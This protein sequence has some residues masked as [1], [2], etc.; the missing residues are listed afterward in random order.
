VLLRTN[1]AV[2]IGVL[3][4]ALASQAAWGE[5]L[6]PRSHHAWGRFPVGSWKQ[7]RVQ[8][9]TLDAKGNVI[10]ASTT[11]TV[12]V[13]T[14][15]DET[16]Y[17]LEVDVTL[18][19]AGKRFILQP[20]IMH[21]GFSG[22]TNGQRAELRP[23][24]MATV[25]I[26]GREIPTEVRES[27]VDDDECQ[28]VN[29]VYYSASVEP[30]VLKRETTCTGANGEK[31]TSQ[32]QVDVLALDM[33]VRLLNETMTSSHVKT[34]QKSAKGTA[35]TLE[36]C[37]MEVPGGVVYHTAKELDS[38]GRVVR[39]GT[40]EIVDYSIGGDDDSGTGRGR[41]HRDRPRR[42]DR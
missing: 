41:R 38:E 7:V 17:T 16:G 15:V 29:R 32:T 21:Q 18:E 19:V 30:Y 13:L 1:F 33:P 20:Q 23:V 35:I 12:T 42:R 5:T 31:T 40:L 34:V 36:I 22:E 26:D 39:R 6:V 27:V 9:E 14:A 24:H 3:A 25:V 4:F 8:N 2:W 10:E 37:C 28:R 11:E